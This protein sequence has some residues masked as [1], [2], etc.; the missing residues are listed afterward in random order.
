[1]LNK[2]LDD[3]HTANLLLEVSVLDSC[4]D[5]V[6]WCSNSD[7]CNSAGNGCNEVLTP[8][9]FMVVVKAEENVLRQCRGT[10][11]LK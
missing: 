5:R 4:L 9:G 3:G 1:M 8:S 7:G 2:L 11:K 6:Q 10:E